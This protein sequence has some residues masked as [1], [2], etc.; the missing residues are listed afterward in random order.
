MASL[1][2]EVFGAPTSSSTSDKA[3][4]SIMSREAALSAARY[5]AAHAVTPGSRAYWGMVIESLER[6]MSA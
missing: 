4:V 6:K 1:S 3:V 2:K 5:H